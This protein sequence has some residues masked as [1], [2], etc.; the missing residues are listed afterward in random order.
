MYQ[1]ELQMR[2]CQWPGWSLGDLREEYIII[3]L[4]FFIVVCCATYD[5]IITKSTL[6]IAVP[7]T[8]NKI[9]SLHIL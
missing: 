9:N 2:N 7:K 4:M 5:L 3:D 6:I 8:L 1:R